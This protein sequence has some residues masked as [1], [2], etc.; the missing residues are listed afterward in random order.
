MEVRRAGCTSARVLKY[1]CVD[2][3]QQTPTEAQTS[4]DVPRLAHSALSE[5]QK[6]ESASTTCQP[7]TSARTTLTRLKHRWAKAASIGRNPLLLSVDG[8]VFTSSPGRVQQKFTAHTIPQQ[9]CTPTLQT[10]IFPKLQ[11]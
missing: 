7:A 3:H 4:L 6:W 2:W 5:H 8:H 11:L 10:L 1:C 9:P